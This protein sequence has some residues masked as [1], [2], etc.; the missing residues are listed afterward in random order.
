MNGA[1][2]GTTPVHWRVP[3]ADIPLDLAAVRGAILR[4]GDEAANVVAEVTDFSA[5]VP[6]SEWTAGDA[7]T[8]LILV[9]RGFTAAIDGR[10]DAWGTPE[11]QELVRTLSD[12]GQPLE[13]DRVAGHLRDALAGLVAA[14]AMSSPDHRFP[15]P[16]YEIDKTNLVG[17]MTCLILG[18]VLFHGCDVAMAMDRPW[19][20]EPE[21]GRRIIG[22]V[23]PVKLP[24]LVDP[25]TAGAA[26]ASYELHVDGGPELVVRFWDGKATVGPGGSAPVDCHLGG[27]PEALLRLVYG[28][29]DVGALFAESRLRAWGD[30]PSLG[31]RFGSLL[32]KP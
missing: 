25:G 21:D 6:G 18:E 8:H 19:P 17:A 23:F 4:V 1:A 32:K 28:R 27:D 14:A 22:G 31:P 20:V 3:F 11:A 15:T 26:R 24:V 13:P 16:W 30:D 2:A 10:L 29:A 9:L 5:P 7:V 12:I